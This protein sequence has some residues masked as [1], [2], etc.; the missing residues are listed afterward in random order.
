M[1]YAVQSV[2][3][4]ESR[5]VIMATTIG[6]TVMVLILGFLALASSETD[7]PMGAGQFGLILDFS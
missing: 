3:G 4:A 1:I 7:V 6:F 5:Q 2:S